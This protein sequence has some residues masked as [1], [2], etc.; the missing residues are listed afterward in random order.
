MTKR[1][2]VLFYNLDDTQKIS[3]KSVILSTFLI[4]SIVAIIKILISHN[5]IILVGNAIYISY[6]ITRPFMYIVMYE[7]VKTIIK[8]LRRVK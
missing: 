4:V 8:E 5:L 3:K 1:K 6:R 2:D 7:I